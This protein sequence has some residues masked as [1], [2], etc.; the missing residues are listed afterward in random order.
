M[1]TISRPKRA[2]FYTGSFNLFKTLCKSVEDCRICGHQQTVT[3]AGKDKAGQRF[4]VNLGQNGD[5]D[6]V[7]PANGFL[8]QA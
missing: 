5:E 4:K 1:C 8:I 6:V 7:T 3:K 2:S